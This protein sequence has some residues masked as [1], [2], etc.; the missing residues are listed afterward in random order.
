MLK[1]L[2]LNQI[3]GTKS[4]LFVLSRAPDHQSFTFNLRLLYELKHKG[5]LSETV[6]LFSLLFRFYKSSYFHS[7]KCMDS[8]TLKIITLLKIKAI[9]KPY[10]VLLPNL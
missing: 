1:K 8:L 3:N 9:E 5:C 7:K 2:P 6:C 10:T 4:A